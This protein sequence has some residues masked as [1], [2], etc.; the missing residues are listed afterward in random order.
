MCW[1]IV[2][3]CI[4]YVMLN[5]VQNLFPW[6]V[7]NHWHAHH[8]NFGMLYSDFA[9]TGLSCLRIRLVAPPMQFRHGC[10]KANNLPDSAPHGYCK[11]ALPQGLSELTDFWSTYSTYTRWVSGSVKNQT[12][13]PPVL[14][15]RP[16]S[17]PS[18]QLRSTI[19]VRAKQANHDINGV[20]FIQWL[21][22]LP[23]NLQGYF[24]WILD[25]ITL[26]NNLDKL[27]TQHQKKVVFFQ[28]ET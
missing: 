18:S 23:Q 11:R 6:M 24:T 13:D 7:D 4:S 2:W 15:L 26:W 3:Q 14:R 10:G 9:I 16:T 28:G 27:N 5:G 22:I 20:L 12:R 21:W 17:S 25:L 1:T 8:L 19:I